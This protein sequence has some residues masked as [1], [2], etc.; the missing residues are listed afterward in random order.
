MKEVSVFYDGAYPFITLEDKAFECSCRLEFYMASG[1]GG[2]KKNRTYSAVRA[3]HKRTTISTVAEESRSQS[4]NK[5]KALKRLKKKIALQV[6]KD[7]SSTGFKVHPEAAAL[8]LKEGIKKI[9]SKNRLYPL[10]CAVLLD[11]IYTSKGK[12]SEASKRLNSSTGK[13]NKVISSDKDIFNAVNSLRSSFG[14][15]SLR[16]S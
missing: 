13:L 16:L 10:Y 8:F 3:T 1:P 14:L 15:N 11:S 5:E 7:F 6:R 9:N 12:L 2:Q 4:D